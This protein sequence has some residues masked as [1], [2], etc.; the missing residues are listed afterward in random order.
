ML[1]MDDFSVRVSGSELRF[2]AAHFIYNP[3]FKEPLH[4]HNYEVEVEVRG[5][6]GDDGFVVNFLDLKEVV[7]R[8]ICELDHRVMLPTGNPLLRVTGDPSVERGIRIV[9]SGG[10]EYFFP[11]RDV[12]L[13]P[14]KDTSAEELARYFAL[15]IWTILRER[16][17]NVEGVL[18]RVYETAHYSAVFKMGA[19]S[20]RP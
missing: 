11:S 17:V 1:D 20:G 13:L 6:L 9:C 16:R 14:V 19:S 3:F 18:T 2:S 10:E 5:N 4:G 12:V 7:K 8:V 15:R